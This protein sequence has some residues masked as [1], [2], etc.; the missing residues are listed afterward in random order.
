M[1]R[2]IFAAA[3]LLMGCSSYNKHMLIDASFTN[4]EVVLIEQGIEDWVLTT[5]SEDAIIYTYD[6]GVDLGT[7]TADKWHNHG[8]DYGVI[9][10]ISVLD[11]GYKA[12]SEE[13]EVSE[14]NGLYE[15]GNIALVSEKVSESNDK[16]NHVFKHELGHMYGLEHTMFGLMGKHGDSV[17]C[18][19][20]SAL[21][22]F[23]E[24]HECGKNVEPECK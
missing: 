4:D 19:D 23:C 21:D 9:F 11:S 3:I 7:F 1:K 6:R 16:F 2:T 22:Q 12:L 24:L 10:K 18:I 8:Y 20:K 13:N 15:D 17:P 14:F 5:R